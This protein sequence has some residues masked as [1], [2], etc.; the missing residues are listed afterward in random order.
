MYFAHSLSH[1]G[2]IGQG[3]VYFA[4]SLSHK[5]SIGQ[6]YV[7]FAPHSVIKEV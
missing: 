3:Y 5:G 6:G 2:S 1:K 7:Y 4:H